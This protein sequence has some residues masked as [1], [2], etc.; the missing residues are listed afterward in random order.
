M[1]KDIPTNSTDILA[2]DGYPKLMRTLELSEAELEN[3]RINDPL[4]IN[5]YKSTRGWTDGKK[6]LDDRAYIRFNI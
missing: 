5:T 1:V 6:A 4:C 2:S 3:L